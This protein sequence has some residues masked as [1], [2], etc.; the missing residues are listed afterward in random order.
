MIQSN[1]K[2]SG[3]L[4][5]RVFG[6]DGRLKDE[7][8]EKNLL[9]STG[10]AYIASRMKDGAATPMTHM[11]LGSSSTAAAAGQ[12]QLGSQL[13]SRVALTATTVA[14]NEVEYTATFAAGEGTGAVVE[15][16]IFNAASGGTMLC[17]TVFGLKT[18]EAGDSFAM[19]WVVS[20]AAA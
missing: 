1:A 11:A 8:V 4:T 16:G 12:T 13:G 10:L 3:K 14:A 7:F 2:V 15:A 19:T 6:A 17:R 20:L 18:K 9:V 5:I